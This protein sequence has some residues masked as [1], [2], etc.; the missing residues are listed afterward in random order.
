[1]SRQPP[2]RRPRRPVRLG[3]GAPA[4]PGPGPRRA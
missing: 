3:A 2:P 4:R 1:A